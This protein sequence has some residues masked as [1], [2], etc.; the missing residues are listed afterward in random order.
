MDQL[1]GLA[2]IPTLDKYP[3]NSIESVKR[4]KGV[5]FD[6]ITVGAYQTSQADIIIKPNKIKT[7]GQ[8]VT[9]ALNAALKKANLYKYDLI[10]KL[11]SDTIIPDDFTYVNYRYG[12]KALGYGSMLLLD[13]RAFQRIN[14]GQF[15]ECSA[16]DTYLFHQ[17][18]STG[19]PV[20]MWASI[21]PVN[22]EKTHIAIL[23]Q[24]RVGLDVSG[25]GARLSIRRGLRYPLMYL[26]YLVGM[27]FRHKLP[28]HDKVEEARKRRWIK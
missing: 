3:M 11:D 25:M 21:I 12:Y 13:R 23:D 10:L 4:Q 7:K 19:L 27:L 8:R 22:R 9:R 5:K 24:F 28:I 15:Y 14:K 18:A 6:I 17:I 16:D 26:G 20:L 1:K 2:L